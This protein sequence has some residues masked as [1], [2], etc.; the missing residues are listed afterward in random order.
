MIT[1][2]HEVLQ[3]T[4]EITRTKFAIGQLVRHKRFDYRGV[5]VD[6]DPLFMGSEEWY[7]EVA[8]SRPPRDKPW[9]RVLVHDASHETYV[10]ERHLQ[11][12]HSDKPINHPLIGD[13]FQSFDSGAGKYHMHLRAN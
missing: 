1:D 5:V 9:Y 4:M 13:F 3:S 7:R 12:D 2:S 11:A 6:V 8:Q 10:A